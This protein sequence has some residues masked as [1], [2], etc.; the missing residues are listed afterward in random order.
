MPYAH[1]QIHTRAVKGKVIMILWYISYL[2]RFWQ[3]S[4][5]M[6]SSSSRVGSLLRCT[7]SY[8]WVAGYMNIG[9][10]HFKHCNT[11]RSKY[12]RCKVQNTNT[13]KDTLTWPNT[14]RNTNTGKDTYLAKHKSNLIGVQCP[15]PDRP[16]R[17][18]SALWHVFVSIS[19]Y[20]SFSNVFFFFV[21]GS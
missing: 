18:R 3:S 5:N 12:G 8:D 14:N 6:S 20:W 11:S 2:T 1:T 19:F 9:I 13:G 21:S 16:G 15:A 10:F 4:P 17:V 7:P